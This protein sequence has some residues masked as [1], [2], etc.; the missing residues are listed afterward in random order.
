MTI[1]RSQEVG[2]KPK[3]PPRMTT[4]VKPERSASSMY[5]N[6]SSSNKTFTRAPP[7]RDNPR[8][9][10]STVLKDFNVAGKQGLAENTSGDRGHLVMT[11]PKRDSP[12]KE[13]RRPERRV[14][15]K[16]EIVGSNVI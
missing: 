13:Q 16:A 11:T 8:V 10:S 15:Y 3:K 2:A 9:Y 4:T 5:S 12:P 7:F 6:A 1:H 14:R